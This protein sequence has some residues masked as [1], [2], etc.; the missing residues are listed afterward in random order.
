MINKTRF[1][2][3]AAG[4]LFLANMAG[5]KNKSNNSGEQTA[6]PVTAVT[7]LKTDLPWDIEYPAQ[8]TGSLE[9][10]IRAQVGG[11]LRE[12][13]YHEGAYVEKGT[14]LFQIDD[15]E[16]SAALDKAKG[17]LAQGE[18]ELK[19]TKRDFN[20]IKSLYA[21]RATS[22]KDY[23]TA[24][25]AYEAAQANLQ[26]AKAEVKNAEINLA[27]TKV[28]APISGIAREEAQSVGSLISPAGATGLLTTMVQVNPLY[29]NFSMPSN[30]FE[31]LVAG[32]VSGEI[33]LGEGSVTLS[34]VVITDGRPKINRDNAPIFVEIILPNGKH[35][36][37]K[38]KIIF[39]DS[40]ENTQTASLAV[41]AQLPNPLNKNR[42]LMPGQFVRVRLLGAVYKN[43][44]LIPSS[45][46]LSTPVANLVYVIK[47]DN[48]IESV[49]VKIELQDD[50]YIVSEGLKGGER[51]V[52]GGL[53][54]VQPKQKVTP[55]MQEFKLKNTV[56]QI[57]PADNE[58]DEDPQTAE[59][60]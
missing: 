8:I 28:S 34:E 55:Q 39:F 20:R 49:P 30:H 18:A 36:P 25:S 10:D 19:R 37:E 56:T 5:C 41:K 31:K 29:I 16:Y 33:A 52:S 47:D 26:I 58:Y 21:D 43:A 4:C 27:Y 44:V 6:L 13:L 35:H 50:I 12:R 24:L 23:D 45:A 51:I 2:A 57:T 53:L 40:A 46:V 59:P 42:V 54:K 15:K 32:F 11:I 17:V 9:V 14:Q 38:G 48:T 3:I 60:L 22:Q 1:I 7:V